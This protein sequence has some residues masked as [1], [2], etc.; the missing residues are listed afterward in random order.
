MH[1]ISIDSVH[2]EIARCKNAGLFKK[3]YLKGLLIAQF[4][5]PIGGTNKT[6]SFRKYHSFDMIAFRSELREVPFVKTPAN[7]VTEL[8]KQYEQDLYNYLDKHVPQ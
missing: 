5:R 1:I 3:D 2:T 4:P 6:L 8:F 7:A